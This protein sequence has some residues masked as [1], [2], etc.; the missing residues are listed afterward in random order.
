M[1][2]GPQYGHVP[3]RQA[4]EAVWMLR[5]MIEQATE[6]Q[7]QVLVMDSDVAAAFD[8][9]SHHEIVRATTDMGVPPVLIAAWIRVYRNSGTMVKLDDIV[10]PGIRR[11]R[12]VPQGDPCAAD[13]LGAVLDRPSVKFVKMCQEMKWGL[14]V[15]GSCVGFLLFADNCWIIAMSA[16]ELQT[17]A[18]AWNKLLRQAGLQIDWREAVWCTTAHDRIP[19]SIKVDDKTISRRPREEGFKALGAWITFDGHLTKEIADRE[20]TAWRRFFALRQFLCDSD[21]ELKYRLRLLAAFVLSSMY[22]CSG[23]WILT[24]TQCAHLRAVLDRMF[25]KMIYV[26]RGNEESAESHMIRWSRLIRN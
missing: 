19:G 8:H 9:V 1:R 10:T 13:L 14:L 6:W 18:S 12:C 4:H 7:I 11:R 3:G 20:V 26:A 2:C 21:V 5:R 15:G 25:R 16:A 22:W 23:S 17:M 24:R